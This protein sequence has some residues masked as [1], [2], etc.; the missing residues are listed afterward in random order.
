MTTLINSVVAHLRGKAYAGRNLIILSD[1]VFLVS[2]PRSG[3]TWLRFMIA[4]LLNP[5][6]ST[7]FLNID[8][9]VGDIYT[10]S[11]EALLQ[12]PRPRILKSHEPF[13]PRYKRVIYVVRDPRDVV[14]SYYHWKRKRR[15]IPDCYPIEE[16]VSLFVKGEIDPNLGSWTQNVGTWLT[17]RQKTPGF[18]LVRYED[19]VEDAQQQLA[20]IAQF[21]KCQVTPDQLRRA[22]SLA[23]VEQMQDLERQ[24][25]QLWKGSKG[26]RQDILFVRQGRA[27]SWRSE[28][29]ASSLSEIE[30]TCG[31][32][33]MALGYRQETRAAASGLSEI[34][35]AVL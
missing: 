5:H 33:M 27:G 10:R 7:T 8:R 22:I 20:R 19:L 12:L 3:N 1:D 21:L 29:P 25:A 34:E 16:F 26:F 30:R 14:V 24:Q 15:A 13:E 17:A 31:P 28:L 35:S 18:A 11:Q 6:E 9:R 23:S 2:Y 4:N 32:V